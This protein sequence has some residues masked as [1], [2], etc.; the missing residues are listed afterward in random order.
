LFLSGVW[1]FLYMRAITITYDWYLTSKKPPMCTLFIKAW[2]K[3]NNVFICRSARL[4]GQ[5][6]CVTNNVSAFF[7][8][9][10]LARLQAWWTQALP[11]FWVFCCSPAF[12]FQGFVFECGCRQF[13]LQKYLR[14]FFLLSAYLQLHLNKG[15]LEKWRKC[16]RQLKF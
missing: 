13:Y 5:L 14:A 15:P 6:R 3:M 7:I 11:L 2:V 8:C 10:R 4:D 16:L 12:W 1:L 9:A